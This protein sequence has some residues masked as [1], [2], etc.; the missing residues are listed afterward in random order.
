MATTRSSSNKKYLKELTRLQGKLC[1]LQ[2]WVKAKGLRVDRHLRRARRR[3]QGRHDQGDHRARQPARLPRRGAAGA[4]RPR[5]EPDV[6]AALHAAL[7][8]PPA[9]SSS[10]TAAGTTAPASST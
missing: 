4:V 6:H 10:S 7:S 9:R 5:K 1:V 3:R 2:D 8:R